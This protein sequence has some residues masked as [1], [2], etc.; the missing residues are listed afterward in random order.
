MANLYL[1]GIHRDK[2]LYMRQESLSQVYTRRCV[3]AVIVVAALEQWR[4]MAVALVAV[5][6]MRYSSSGGSGNNGFSS[7]TSQQERQ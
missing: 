7:G 1:P 5:A 4:Y 2:P 6:T 3:V